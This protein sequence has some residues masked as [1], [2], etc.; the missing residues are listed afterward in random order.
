MQLV[1][2]VDN[3]FER[4]VLFD[5]IFALCMPRELFGDFGFCLIRYVS[6]Q[7]VA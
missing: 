5:Q 7:M 4:V 1:E 6:D 2:I 3:G